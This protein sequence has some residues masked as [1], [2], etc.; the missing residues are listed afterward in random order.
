MKFQKNKITGV[1][2]AGGKNRR[3]GSQKSLAKI[4]GKRLIDRIIAAMSDVFEEN[5]IITNNEDLYKEF[6]LKTYPDILAGKGPLMG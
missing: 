6:N 3:F 1:I 2:L 4:N 5:I